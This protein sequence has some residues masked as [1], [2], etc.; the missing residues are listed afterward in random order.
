MFIRVHVGDMGLALGIMKRYKRYGLA[1]SMLLCL[2]AVVLP[3]ASA[4]EKLV[5][6]VHP[7]KTS[8]ALIKAFSPLADYLSQK[9]NLEVG[10]EISASY[11]S[12]V[13]RLGNNKVDLAYLGPA[14]YVLLVG[15]FG[16]HP[17][18][19]RQLINGQPFFQG[20]LIARHDS[21]VNSLEE[22]QGKRFAFGD[23]ASTMSH[24]VPRYMLIKAGIGTEKL[25]GHQFLG[26]HDNVAMGVLSGDFDAG[27]VKEAVFYKYQS[28]GLKALAT[29]PSIPEHL[30]VARSDLP[31]ETVTAL[32]QALLDLNA[33]ADGRRILASIKTT[34]TA[35]E[36]AVDSDYD[37]L[38]EIFSLLTKS[39]IQ[40]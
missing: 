1:V 17:I 34:I 38:R 5:L 36:P 25:S 2:N 8:S 15:K 33:S 18:L 4:A 7:Y 10:L 39:G 13:G 9:L 29:T 19:A 6:A 31:A 12:H 21:P 35:L 40:P 20:K 14:S 37:V 22:L 28:R 32:S 26:S 16:H 27:A 11:Q 3:A 30:F 23:S 24:L